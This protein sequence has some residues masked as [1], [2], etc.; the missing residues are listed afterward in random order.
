MILGNIINILVAS[1]YVLFDYD[2]KEIIESYNNLD[3]IPDYFKNAFVM[4]IMSPFSTAFHNASGDMFI[5][6]K[7]GDF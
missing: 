2:T 1:R 3:D 7:F 4:E 5:T 6:I